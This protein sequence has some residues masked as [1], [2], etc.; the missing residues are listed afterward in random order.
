LESKIINLL[1]A[2]RR[3]YGIY[4]QDPEVIKSTVTKPIIIDSKLDVD[5]PQALPKANDVIKVKAVEMTQP[6]TEHVTT[7]KIKEEVK[8]T[9]EDTAKTNAKEALLKEQAEQM[10]RLHE[11]QLSEFTNCLKL[12]EAKRDEF[13]VRY[14]QESS[15]DITKVYGVSCQLLKTLEQCAQSYINGLFDLNQ[16]KTNATQ[17]IRDKRN[18]IL[19]EHRGFKEIL[20]N[21]L[22]AIGTLGVGYAIAALFTHRLAPISI[23]TDSINKLDQVQDTLNELGVGLPTL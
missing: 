18:G 16:F 12:L 19:S 21:F 14:P 5:K 9:A 22:L 23:N 8:P 11:R 4:Q 17:A 2:N 20:V 7:T 15:D 10:K 13:H 3:L 6:T 1:T